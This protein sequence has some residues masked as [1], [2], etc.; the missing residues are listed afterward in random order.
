MRDRSRLGIA[1]RSRQIPEEPVMAWRFTRVAGI[2]T[3]SCGAGTSFWLSGA[4]NEKHHLLDTGLPLAYLPEAIEAYWDEHPKVVA[5]RVIKIVGT[6][7]PYLS[8]LAYAHYMG[9]LQDEVL[10]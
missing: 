10:H 9:H 1:T 8:Q 6:A 4:E 3:L 5:S 7:T 2:V